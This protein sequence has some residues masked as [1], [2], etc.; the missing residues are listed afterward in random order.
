MALRRDKIEQRLARIERLAR[1]Q[2]DQVAQLRQDLGRGESAEQ[3]W[4][5]MLFELL[6]EID[7]RGG[8]VPRGEL[9]E[10]GESIGYGR[11]GL[12]G[13][14]QRLLRLQDD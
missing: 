10:I 1:D 14:Y 8:S 6:A 9:L 5:R 12:A 2:L 3:M 7:R 11:Q 13:H 4:A